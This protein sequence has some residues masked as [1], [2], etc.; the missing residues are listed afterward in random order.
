MSPNER[1]PPIENITL[2]NCQSRETPSLG[3]ETHPK[4]DSREVS[5]FYGGI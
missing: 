1:N 5:P 4:T 3:K 2:S